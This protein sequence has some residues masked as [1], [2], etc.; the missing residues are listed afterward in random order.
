MIR[1]CSFLASTWIYARAQTWPSCQQDGV[2]IRN[3]NKAF[4]TNLQ[5]FGATVGC[6]QDDCTNSDKF[7]G[8]SI[9]HCAKVCLSLPECEFWVWGPEDGEQKCWF[10][11]ADD[12]REQG[13]GFI[14]GAKACHP[15]GQQAVPMGNAECWIDGFD[16][17]FCC[18]PKLGPGGKPQCWDGEF[19]VTRCCFPKEL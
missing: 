19:N 7:V 12:G 13:K 8:N 9:E 15:P 5:G 10:R 17:N 16:Y 18:D 6:F 14:S 4:F 2:V 3:A 1:F 11:F